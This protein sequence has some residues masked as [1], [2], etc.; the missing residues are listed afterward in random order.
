MK[1]L[2]RVS[3]IEICIERQIDKRSEIRGLRLSMQ[4]HIFSYLHEHTN[5]QILIETTSLSDLNDKLL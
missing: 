2:Q 5:S 3:C 4:R 1:K